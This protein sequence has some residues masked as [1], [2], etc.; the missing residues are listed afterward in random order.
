MVSFIKGVK[1]DL[2]NSKGSDKDL[3]QIEKLIKPSNLSLIIMTLICF[4]PY[5]NL[6]LKIIEKDYAE[7]IVVTL[8]VF[9]TLI[10]MSVYWY[11]HFNT[12]RNYKRIAKEID[13]QY[14]R[15]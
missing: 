9:P 13:E 10:L 4:G 5:G 8:I 3:K 12:L 11:W 1:I 2:N 7:L 14:H 6:I 15:D